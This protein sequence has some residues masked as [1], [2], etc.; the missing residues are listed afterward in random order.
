MSFNPT[1]EITEDIS[2]LL[3]EINSIEFHIYKN[4]NHREFLKKYWLQSKLDSIHSACLLQKKWTLQPESAL[5][6]LSGN[7]V[8]G[9]SNT[10][11]RRIQ[12]YAR[13]LDGLS[14][15]NPYKPYRIDELKNLHRDL[16]A[17]VGGKGKYDV[18]GQIRTEVIAVYHND[19]VK[20]KYFPPK[21]RELPELL[22]S[23]YQWANHAEMDE[24]INTFVMAAVFHHRLMELRPFQQDNGKTARL[25]LRKQLISVIHSWRKLLPLETIFTKDISL[26]YHYLDNCEFPSHDFAYRR[27]PKLTEWITYFLTSIS[28][29][30]S[31][32]L[33]QLSSEPNKKSVS[34]ILN[35]RQKK[36]LQYVKRHGEI[37]NREYRRLFD[38]G[39]NW[40]YKELN[41]M[42]KK[43]Y[44]VPSSPH[45]RSVSYLL[46]IIASN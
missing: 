27:G 24:L 29:L 8:M 16:R 40:A 17:G 1:Y 3:R 20:V 28:D 45:G 30:L 21:P 14:M 22:E 9:A 37:S 5:S 13:L 33:S 39:R 36:A 41:D 23:L 18:A 31:D 4:P 42:V 26:Y 38:I 43:G 11:V 15:W 32:L 2:R 34:H 35:D 12:N 46:N 10:E 44:L 19:G 7:L 6:A 25:Y